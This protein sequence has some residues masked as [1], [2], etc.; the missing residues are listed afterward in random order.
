MFGYVTLS[1][2]SL[3]MGYG[4]IGI[5]ISQV[6]VAVAVTGGGSVF[7]SKK[8]LRPL[9]SFNLQNG[10]EIFRLAAPLGLTAILTTIYYKADFVMLSYMKSDTEVGYYNAAYT[11]VNTLLLFTTT[12][13]ATML[14]RLSSLFT[15]DTEVLGRLYRTA[16][17]YLLFTGLGCAVGATALAGPI[18]NF[19]F[20]PEYLPGAAALAILIWASALMFVNSLQGSL[21]VASN[22]KRQLMYMTGAGAV[23]NLI[24]NF[25]LIPKFGLRGAAVATVSSEVIAG[26]WSFVLLS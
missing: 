15:S 13:T 3:W 9:L 1:S 22:L 8:I 20:G 5:G 6:V 19:L 12:F 2:L 17:K 16:F 25:M 18:M 23:A 21:L 14:P 10:W 4:L 26:T 7:V 11:I 24:L